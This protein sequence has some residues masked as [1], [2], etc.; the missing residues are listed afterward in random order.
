[1]LCYHGTTADNLESILKNGLIC[2]S[3]KL[4]TVSHDAV[5]CYS[6]NLLTELKHEYDNGDEIEDYHEQF[7]E[8]AFDS[9]SCGLAK[10]KDCRAVVVVFEVDESE[11]EDDDSCPNMD[12]ANCVRRSIKPEEIKEI[13]VSSD[14][15]AL[16]GYFLALMNNM[17][18]FNYYPNYME[19]KLIKIFQ[20]SEIYPED[21]QDILEWESVEMAASPV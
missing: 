5:Y 12:V 11:L 17:P 19:Q 1:M 2:E 6:A 9:A 7:L 13:Y 18:L 8:R 16:K 3:N 4:W 21:I 14:L 10:A 15:A 20:K